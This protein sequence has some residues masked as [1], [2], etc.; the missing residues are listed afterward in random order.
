MALKTAAVPHPLPEPLAE[1]IAKRF[2]VLSE[3]MR[4]RLLD[5]LRM[6]PA[7]VTELQEATGSS[8]QNVSKHLGVLLAAGVVSREKDRNFSRYAIAD[9][10]VFDLCEHVCGGL[11]QQ[12]DEFESALQGGMDS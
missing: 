4:L 10:G 7:T 2:Q 6:A 9:E 12:L 11:R 3:P 8:Q 5:S 1:L